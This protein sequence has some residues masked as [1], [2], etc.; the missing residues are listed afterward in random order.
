MDDGSFWSIENLWN[1]DYILI[2][3]ICIEYFLGMQRNFYLVFS[4]SGVI[5]WNE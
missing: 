1:F 2:S 3:L 4:F 5:S